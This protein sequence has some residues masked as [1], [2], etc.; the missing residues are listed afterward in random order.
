MT[1]S[2]ALSPP[3]RGQC[4]QQLVLPRCHVQAVLKLAH[5]GTR[6]RGPDRTLRRRCY[7][8]Q[9]ADAVQRYCNQCHRCQIA[10]KPGIGVHQP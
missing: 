2:S 10:R 6:H 8:P 1:A 7:W 9:M 3:P 5:D 4:W